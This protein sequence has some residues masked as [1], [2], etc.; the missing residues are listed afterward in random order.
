MTAI[1]APGASSIVDTWFDDVTTAVNTLVTAEGLRAYKTANETLGN[2]TTYQND[3][4]LFIPMAANTEY[5]GELLMVL[6]SDASADFKYQLTYPAGATLHHH[7]YLCLNPTAIAY[8]YAGTGEVNFATNGA[9]SPQP[10]RTWFAVQNGANAGN[11]QIQWAKN[12]AHAST[13]TVYR[14]SYLRLVATAVW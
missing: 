7:I 1:V 6:A 11:L 14:G 13:T 9:S 3:D 5:Y 12:L 10:L 8:G 2:S 4:H